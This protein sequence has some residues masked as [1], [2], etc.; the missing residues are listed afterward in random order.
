MERFL[1]NKSFARRI[2]SAVAVFCAASFSAHAQSFIRDAEIEAI[3]RDFTN[4]I[5]EAANL[6]PDDVSIYLINDQ[7]LNA[8]VARG[9]NIHLHTGLIMA[10]ETPG[11]LIG[12]IA[13]ETGHIEGGHN[14]RRQRDL[15]IAS[16]PA[17]VSIGL[18]LLAIA[19]GAPDAGAALIAS[20]QQFGYLNFASHTRPQEAS[21]D[22]AALRY[23][24]ATGRSPRGLLEFFENFRDIQFS[25]NA[26][27]YRYFYTHPLA[28]DRI[29]SLR[30]GAERS[31]LMD[32][33]DS[34][35]EIYQLE[36]MK[37]KLYG[38]IMAPVY[39][40]RE[41]P[42]SDQSVP[43]RYA[44]AISAFQNDSLSL[45]LTLTDELIQEFPENPY[46]HELE[47]QILFENGRFEDSI[48]PNRRALELAGRVPLLMVNLARSLSAVQ[49]PESLAEA[50]ELLSLATALEAGN[51]Y[52]WH[53]L[54]I[55]M[56]RQG[57]RAEA[58]LAT[59]EQAFHYGDCSRARNFA[60]RAAQDLEPNT[61]TGIRASDITRICTFS[62][63]R[64]SR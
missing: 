27:R 63:Q 14:I 28:S 21:A 53:E 59:A 18:G 49:T 64:R 22:Q 60:A 58:D 35:E 20:S 48:E 6:R 5:L 32:L 2:V 8:F 25:N 36:I 7:T 16:R 33:E 62:A 44:R 3:L 24:T 40:Q 51:A 37:A 23:M 19:A 34:E 11:Q 45:A 47:G 4:P 10:S 57:R 42:E 9:Q 43:A 39:V 61:P 41:Y 50:E 52:A 13:H 12:V 46:F 26:E 54:A 17:F 31:G 38:F 15:E 56:E 55:V 30:M 29:E 1:K